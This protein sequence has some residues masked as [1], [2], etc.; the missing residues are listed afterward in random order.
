M[1][2][3]RRVIVQPI[4]DE[5]R[6]CYVMRPAAWFWRAGKLYVGYDD[7]DGH[8]QGNQPHWD[9]QPVPVGAQVETC[10]GIY[11]FEKVLTE[12]A[13]Y[14]RQ[15]AVLSFRYNY[16]PNDRRLSSQKRLDQGKVVML[17]Q[18]VLDPDCF[19]EWQRP[20]RRQS[21]LIPPTEAAADIKYW[22]QRNKEW[23]AGKKK[24]LGPAQRARSPMKH[25]H[26][27]S[28]ERA[29]VHRWAINPQN[30][31]RRIMRSRSLDPLRFSPL[32]VRLRE[33]EY[34]PKGCCRCGEYVAGKQ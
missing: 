5:A 11:R 33:K 13:P 26:F 22:R 7:G 29:L 9:P 20:S 27:G 15:Y 23:R 21:Y 12:G 8:T 32:S 18:M 24:G 17:E 30:L 19:L 14:F 10:G 31:I 3:K 25:R 2:S 34:H 28:D 4:Q 6:L 16:Y 1:T